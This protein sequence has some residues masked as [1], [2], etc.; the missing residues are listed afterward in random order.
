M[1]GQRVPTFVLGTRGRAFRVLL[2]EHIQRLIAIRLQA[3]DLEAC[4]AEAMCLH[5]SE[6]FGTVNLIIRNPPSPPHPPEDVNPSLH[7]FRVSGTVSWNSGRRS[8]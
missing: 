7:N 8:Q 4:G 1:F 6:P 3:V 2:Q 5:V